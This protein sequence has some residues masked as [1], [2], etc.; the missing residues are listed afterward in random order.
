MIFDT[1][2]K[3]ASLSLPQAYFDPTLSSHVTLYI[4]PALYQ[5]FSSF[6]IKINSYNASS[7]QNVQII[8][9]NFGASA[10][11]TTGNPPYTSL[12]VNQEYA[13]T[14]LWTPVTSNVY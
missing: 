5:L 13:T 9:D 14:S 6:P 4:N 10:T 12:I 2:T 8:V 3:L 11:E 7:G 1:T